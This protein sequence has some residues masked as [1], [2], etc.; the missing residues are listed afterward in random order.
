[1]MIMNMIM[2]MMM[3][4]MMM[5]VMMMIVIIITINL[6]SRFLNDNY[7]Y[8]VSTWIKCLFSIPRIFGVT[9]CYSAELRARSVGL[10]SQTAT[11]FTKGNPPPTQLTTR[12]REKIQRKR[13]DSEHKCL[14][15]GRI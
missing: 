2:V 14:H 5:V 10:N 7:Y 11:Q 12:H 6:A 9:L 8:V 15:S 4:L 1:M 3:M 13:G